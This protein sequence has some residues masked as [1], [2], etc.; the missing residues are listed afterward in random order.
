[1]TLGSKARTT[2]ES[3]GSKYI[4]R[5]NQGGEIEIQVFAE[6][7]A[8]GIKYIVIQANKKLNGTDHNNIRFMHG[9]EARLMEPRTLRLLR[10]EDSFPNKSGS[11]YDFLD[12]TEKGKEDEAEMVEL[13]ALGGSKDEEGGAGSVSMSSS[14]SSV[15]RRHEPMK[16]DDCVMFA[17]PDGVVHGIIIQDEGIKIKGLYVGRDGKTVW[18][19]TPH[20]FEPGD[21]RLKDWAP[22]GEE[23]R[24][25]FQT[26]EQHFAEKKENIATKYEKLNASIDRMPKI[27][28]IMI[29]RVKKLKK[30]LEIEKERPSETT[31]G[32]LVTAKRSLNLTNQKLKTEIDK[33]RREGGIKTNVDS[34]LKLFGHRDAEAEK[35]RKLRSDKKN[36]DKIISMLER[37][38][39][40]KG[41]KRKRKTKR[42][43]KRRKRK[44]KKSTRRKR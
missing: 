39:K 35:Y 10:Y 15:I 40:K 41:G 43:R 24:T 44:K 38:I 30:I 32:R 27:K 19:I 42:K 36:A 2:L 14:A 3:E 7:V 31:R 8:N 23:F 18:G 11:H 25:F 16:E 5:L 22:T 13:K 17:Y 20:A 34:I 33:M 4:P 12:L 1:M 6:I 29:E 26:Y 37:C 28:E 9:D 21:E